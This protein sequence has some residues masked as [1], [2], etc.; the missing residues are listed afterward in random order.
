[1]IASALTIAMGALIVH[2]GWQQGPPPQRTSSR[3]LADPLADA[4]PLYTGSIRIMSH[5]R[6]HLGQLCREGMIDNING[7]ILFIRTIPCRPVIKARAPW[8][9]SAE[10]VWTAEIDRMAAFREGFRRT[11]QH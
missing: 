7:T 6:P 10:A 3:L 11:A 4:D 8:R 2:A 5:P 1:M 9:P